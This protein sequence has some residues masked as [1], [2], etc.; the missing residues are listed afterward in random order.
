MVVSRWSPVFRTA[1]LE[2]AHEQTVRQHDQV[3]VPCLALAVAKLTV[4]HAKLLLAVPMIGLRACPAI[5]IA[6]D[7]APHF[8]AY[9]IGDE[10]LTGLLVSSIIPDDH[11]SHLV[12][13]VGNANRAGEVPLP[14]VAAAD[15]FASFGRDRR[16][17]LF[18]LQFFAPNSDLAVELQVAH[19]TARLS[20]SILLAWMWFRFSALVK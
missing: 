6:A 11:D 8:P 10:N 19:I 5:S 14:L 15:F 7:D 12:I 17:E 18:G 2:L 13:H 9:S 20:E 16:G 3:H 1:L 4:S